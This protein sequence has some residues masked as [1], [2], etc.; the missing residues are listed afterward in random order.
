M[1][2]QRIVKV[3]F[4]VDGNAQM[5]KHVNEQIDYW[6]RRTKNF[7]G[8]TLKKYARLYKGTPRPETKSTPWPNAANNVIQ[9]IATQ[10]DT[11]LSRVMAIYMTDPLW[12]VKLLGELDEGVD[13][14]ELKDIVEGFMGDAALDS[15]ALDMYRVE[16]SW[17]S[18]VNRYGTGVIKVPYQYTVEQ[19]LINMDGVDS[20]GYKPEFKDWTKYD[21]PRPENVPLN[22]FVTNLNYSRL[23]DSP[24]KFEICPLS[25]YQLQERVALGLYSQEKVNKILGHIDLEGEELQKY[26]EETQGIT[27]ST[28]DDV[29]AGALYHIVEVWFNYWHNDQKFSL[30]A[31]CHPLSKTNILAFYNYYPDNMCIYEDA[32]LAYDD[33]QYLGYGL[34]EMLKGYQDEISTSHNQKIDAGTL[35]NTT[36]FRINKNSKLRSILTFY[37]GIMIPADKEEVERLDTSNAYANDTSM[38][39]L[40]YGYA[41]ERSGIDPAISGAG[42]GIVNPKR[43]NY[44]AGATFAVMQASNNRT[45]LRTSDCRNAHTRAGEKIS[46]IYAYFGIG[47]KIG[48]Y[49]Q[50]AAKIK[51]AFELIKA[52][53]M[54]ILLRPSS[55]S[56]NKEIE[57]QNDILLSQHL[58]RLY[59][60]DAQIMQLLVTAGMPPDLRD[61]YIAVLKAKNAF[62]KHLLRNFGRDDVNALIP[63]PSFLKDRRDG[64]PTGTTGVRGAISGPGQNIPTLPI[65]GVP[66]ANPTLPQ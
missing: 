30:V 9:V 4:G 32:K 2:Q 13:G 29:S 21:G 38:E 43:G 50:D 64:I 48:A 31:H 44:S 54:G 61:Y 28:V 36:A 33:D 40:T 19:Q 45:S 46:K 25:K 56:I 14:V 37:P 7:R 23:S 41:K 12:P 62:M 3:Q 42:G 27:D 17:F 8:D 1:P 58:E 57:K 6:L 65:A 49:G 47:N 59:A 18:S 35:N 52:H 20:P 66:G 39:T 63:V 34:A 53:R 15:S 22:R 24:F 51:K 55:A 26:I 5:W 16:Q 60:G 10:C 11:L